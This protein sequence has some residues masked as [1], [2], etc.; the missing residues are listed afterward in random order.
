MKNVI[1]IIGARTNNLQSVDVEIPLHKATMVVGVSGSGKSSLLADTLATEVNGRMRRFLGVHQ[2]HLGDQDVPAFI[3]PVPACIHFAQGAFRA[4]R[5]TTVATSSGLLALLRVYFRR[6]AKPWA[7]EVKSFVTPPSASTYEEWIKNHY[8]GSV[9]VWIV[10]A[11]WERTDGVRIANK[12]RRHGIKQ[13]RVRSETDTGTRR[14]I[15]REIDLEKFRP[16]SANTRHL[17]EAEIG[18]TDATSKSGA[19]LVLLQSAFEMGGDVIVEFDKSNTLPEELSDERGTLL[20]STQHWVHP[21]VLLPFAPP[22]DALLSFNSPS[23]PRGGACRSCQG[24]G[25]VRTV[26]LNSFV[27]HPERSL[28]KGALSLWT[29]KNYRYVNIQHETIEGLRD[30]R[31]FAPDKP[32]KGLSKDAR[33]LIL[34]GSG[35][36]AIA[37]IDLKTG[38]KVS[39]PR[40]FPGFI[41]TILRRSEGNGAGARALGELI[42]EGPCPDC[43]G[44]RWSRE[45]RALCLGR[46]NLPSLLK[47]TFDEMKKEA[48]P[49]GSIA[50]GLPEKALSL[51]NGLQ[52]S[53]EAFISAGLGHLSGERGMT[54]LSEGESRRS[55][56]AALLRT[57]GQGLGLLLDEPAR[58]LHEED[59]VRLGSA[60]ADLKQRH[61]LVINEHRISLAGVADRV[62]E[63]GPGAGSQGGRI[64]NSGPPQRVFTKDWYPEIKRSRLP[65]S[66]SGPWLAVKGAQLHTLHNIDCRIPLGRLT[67]ITGVSGSGKSTFI[68][69][70]LLPALIQSL[71]KQVEADGFTWSGGTWKGIT[72]TGEIDSVLALEPRSPGA[73]RRSTV[74]TLLGLAEDVRRIFGAAPEARKAGLTATDFGWN[75]GRGRCQTCLGLGEV[76]DGDTWV[77]CPHCGGR[78]FGEEALGV[79][80]EGLSVADLLYLP[81]VDVQNHPFSALAR[82]KLI[83]EQVVA[84]D[85]GYLTLGRRID[86]L[87]GGEHQRLRVARTLGTE[88]PEGLFLVLD[89]PSAGLHPYDVS[90]LLLVLDRVVGDGRNTVVLVEHNLSLIRA[91]DWVV[92]FGPGGGPDGGQIVGQGPPIKIASRN[93]PTG[94][95][96]RN[97]RFRI[98][99]FPSRSKRI[100]AKTSSD[101][102]KTSAEDSARSG[103]Q[104]L[105]RL[106]GE[107]RSSQD[108]DPVDFENLAVMFDEKVTARPYE[109]GGLDIEIARILLDQPDDFS[110]HPK[111]MAHN[112]S[113]APKAQLQIHPLVEEMR[114]WGNKIPSSVLSEAKKR[115]KHMGLN[116]ELDISSPAKLASVRSTGKRFESHNGTIAERLRCVSDALGIGGGYVE[117]AKPNGEVLETLEMRGFDFKEP[118]IAPLSPSSATLSRL[119]RAGSCPCCDGMGVVPAFDQSLAIANPNANPTSDR[120]LRP[121][122]LQILRGVRRSILLPFFKRMSDEGLW[123]AKA[124]FDS[125]SKDERTILLHGYWRRPGPGSFLKSSKSNPEEVNSWLRWNGLFRVVLEE[126]ERSK[127]TDWVSEIK[128]TS[129]AIKCPFCVGTG[130]HIQSRAIKLGQKSFFDWIQEGTVGTLAKALKEMTPAST[131]SE[132]T[133]SRVLH[134]LEPLVRAIPRAPLNEEIEDI[135]LLRAVFERTAHSM[136]NLKV[137][138]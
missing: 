97:K 99:K 121:E 93:T 59:V 51:A 27:V 128:A 105:R 11:R 106:L 88:R 77:S 52:G 56:L 60:L 123:S 54:T 69:G 21:K 98:R 90:R 12:L 104:W 41:P 91:S 119:H 110:E 26:M 43:E 124:S 120:F 2:P 62:L 40:P 118:A 30:L 25:Q 87:S 79:R 64:V 17:I 55:R 15:G 103:R 58:G 13:I 96:L 42:S 86:R 84:L 131:R 114:V 16:L 75:A 113:D 38:R 36:E 61:T 122:A 47:L 101:H 112:W 83:V 73:Q 35:K 81:I 67:C 129:G 132:N 133:R 85:L 31:G 1:E 46:W 95:V 37:D 4:S 108:L 33:D 102:H 45:A 34:H 50:K 5:R 100:P 78:R 24:L 137:I 63:I 9:S 71:P 14:D 49:K 10:M 57:S 6:Y 72:G 3:G 28:H 29:E 107:E 127:D 76:E 109:I 92:D 115:L 19:L 117:L 23:N 135:K 116:S 22:G 82:W 138:A 7:E 80:V 48:S 136:T 111:R 20:D 65:V 74:A 66:T 125:L 70:I 32:W 53:A 39:L 44:T 68:R 126:I 134:C 89:E 18:E 130:L 8:S 94:R